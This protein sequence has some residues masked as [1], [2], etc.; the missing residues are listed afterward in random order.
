MASGKIGNFGQLGGGVVGQEWDNAATFELGPGHLILASSTEHTLVPPM[1][2][3][4]RP[5][6][7]ADL[8]LFFRGAGAVF[9]V[10]SMAW[11][12]ALSHNDYD[13]E[14][15]VITGNVL[16]RFIDRAPFPPVPQTPVSQTG[17]P[18]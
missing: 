3:A 15:A 1:F 8:V 10:S 17:D 5:D 7:H 11:C 6:Y 13:N 12:G 14:I 2:G 16:A 18:A 9:S 4:M